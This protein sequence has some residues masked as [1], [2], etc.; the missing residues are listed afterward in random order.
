MHIT[1][2]VYG[3]WGDLRPHVVLG[4][5][6]QAAGHEVQVVASKGYEAWV[7]ARN[8]G[9]YPLTDDVNT[10]AK[11]NTALLDANIVQQIQMAR[12]VLNPV[13]TQMGLEVLEATRESDVLMTVEFGAAL[14]FDVLRV[15][16]LKTILI[17]PAPLNPTR[18]FASVMP[19]APGWF[20]FPE[21][22][23]RLSYSL[24]QRVAWMTLSGARN[25]L[26]TQHLKLPK[27]KFK[28]FQAM[29]AVTPALTTVSKH[30]VQRPADWDAHFQVTGYVFDDDPAWTPPQDLVDFLAAGDKPVYIGFGSMPDSKPEAT[31][32]LLIDAVQQTGKRAVILTGWAGLGV[33]DVP[34]SIHILKYAP[35]SW[36]FPQMAAVVHHGGSGTT[37]SGFRAGVPSIIVPHTADQPYWGRRVWQL[38][39]GTEPIPRKKLTVNRLAAAITEATTDRGMQ[40]KAAELSRKI[41]T[42][43]GVGEAVKAIQM[44][45]D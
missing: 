32:R 11:E 31:T 44:F 36:L 45:L 18:E 8:L 33:D 6:L 27:S 17:N 35:H 25:T 43:D 2:F 7:R 3:T 14:L 16:K 20:P 10:I 39:V 9:F 40:D 13:L 12:K 4:M 19:P 28:D 41:A 30:L 37:A 34:E 23:N 38:G 21:W 29:L 42:E 22:F 1:I 5:A 24:L 15:N 26:A